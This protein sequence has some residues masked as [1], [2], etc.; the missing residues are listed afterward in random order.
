MLAKY[1]LSHVNE[2]KRTEIREKSNIERERE[3][4]EKI[5]YFVHEICHAWY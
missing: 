5:V 3:R 4:E 2:K 1:T